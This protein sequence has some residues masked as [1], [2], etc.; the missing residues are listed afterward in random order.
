MG[1]GLCAGVRL[2]GSGFDFG[3]KSSLTPFFH[4][5]LHLWRQRHGFGTVFPYAVDLLAP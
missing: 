2:N 4:R 5:A 3:P 1:A